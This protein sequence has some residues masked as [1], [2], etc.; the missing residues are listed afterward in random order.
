MAKKANKL[1]ILR[2]KYL[3]ARKAACFEHLQRLSSVPEKKGAEVREGLTDM[4]GET[5]KVQ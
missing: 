4:G 1:Y 2:H 3:S 5:F